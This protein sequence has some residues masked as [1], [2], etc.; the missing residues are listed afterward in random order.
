MTIPKSKSL[1]RTFHYW[2]K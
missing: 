1:L 2:A